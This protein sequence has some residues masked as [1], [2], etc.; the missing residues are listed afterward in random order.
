MF[1]FLRNVFSKD[2]GY[3]PPEFEPF[4]IPDDLTSEVIA[5]DPNECE[6]CGNKSNLVDA[7]GG[8][9]SCGASKPV[10]IHS[11]RFDLPRITYYASTDPYDFS[12][13]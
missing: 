2:G 12:S 7:R 10:K 8:C 4:E 1:D 9:I 6:Y 5:K 3:T 13:T 11:S